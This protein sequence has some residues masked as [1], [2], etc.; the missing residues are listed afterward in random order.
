M[1]SQSSTPRTRNSR[2]HSLTSTTQEA[3]ADIDRAA[4]GAYYIVVRFVGNYLHLMQ[5]K[6]EGPIYTTTI[7]ARGSEAGQVHVD[8]LPATNLRSSRSRVSRRGPNC[9]S[10]TAN[11]A[12][13]RRAGQRAS[14]SASDSA[15]SASDSSPSEC[16]SSTTA[17]RTPRSGGRTMSKNTTVA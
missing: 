8:A 14:A 11:S 10:A 17:G 3:T 1:E 6:N 4:G 7:F 16:S 15:D 2:C 9:T 5:I 13:S 12:G